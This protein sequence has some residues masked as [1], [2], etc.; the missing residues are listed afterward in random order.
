MIY[1]LDRI[2]INP[3]IRFGKPCVRGTRLSVSDVLGTLAA[4]SSEAELPEDFQ[5]LTHEDVFACMALSPDERS[6]VTS[7]WGAT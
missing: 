5:Q 2:T 4:G 7:A 1:R 3:A 6:S